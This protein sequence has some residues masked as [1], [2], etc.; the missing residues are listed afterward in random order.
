MCNDQEA[1]ALHVEK[2]N[3]IWKTAANLQAEDNAYH[4]Y[5]ISIVPNQKLTT[6]QAN[7]RRSRKYGS[8]APGGLL[9]VSYSTRETPSTSFVI[10]KLTLLMNSFGGYQKSAVRSL[11]TLCYIRYH[12]RGRHTCH[13]V[14]SL[15]CSKSDLCG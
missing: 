12:R 11:R 15:Y 2:I 4:A 3:P 1:I 10:L 9:V 5:S 6:I 14:G 13:E 8:D 7:W